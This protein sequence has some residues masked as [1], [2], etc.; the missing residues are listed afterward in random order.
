MRKPLVEIVSHCYAM[1]LPHYADALCYQLSSFI[2]H[3]PQ[4]CDVVA[5]ICYCCEDEKTG[6]VVKWFY[7]NSELTINPCITTPEKLGRRAISRNFVASLSSAD[8][9]WF[10]DVDQVYR[11]GILDRLVEMPW[12]DDVV[13]VFP[14]DIMIHRDW[15]TGDRATQALNGKP[16]LVNISVAEFVPKH[17]N[18]AIGGVQIVRGDFARRYGYLNGHP[19]WQQPRTDGKMFGDFVDDRQ[20]RGFCGRHGKIVGV[21]LPGLYRIRHS[22]TSYQAPKE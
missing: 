16:R 4:K 2:M 10:A 8:F 22:T 11:D 20:Y 14:Q 17:Y 13:M 7:D 15:K 18:R 5:S 19:K 12:P 9:V 1:E 6:A 21:D 3:P